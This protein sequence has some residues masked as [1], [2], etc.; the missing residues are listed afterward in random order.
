MNYYRQDR[1][2]EILKKSGQNSEPMQRLQAALLTLV[3]KL[4]WLSN[5][6]VTKGI[7]TISLDKEYQKK[8]HRSFHPKDNEKYALRLPVLS[9]TLFQIIHCYGT[10]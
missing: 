5:E 7:N 2:N 4:V 8:F 10:A 6:S 1:A 9:L 3:D